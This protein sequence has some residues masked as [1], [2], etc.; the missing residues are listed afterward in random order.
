[1]EHEPEHDLPLDE[2]HEAGLQITNGDPG[3]HKRLY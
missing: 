1:M 2:Y 3:G